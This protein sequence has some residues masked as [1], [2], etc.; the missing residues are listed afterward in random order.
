[1]ADTVLE[2]LEKFGNKTF[3]RL[4]FGEVDAL[5][6]SQ[7]SY[8]KFDGIV[9]GPDD[10]DSFVSLTDIKNHPK[11]DDLFSD[12]RYEKPN[13]K[14]FKLMSESVRFGD[15][16]LDWYVNIIGDEREI[17]FS[18]VTFRFPEG[19]DYVAY[20]GTDENMVG[21]KED[22]NLSIMEEIPG[23]K[24]AVK[25]LKEAAK[26]LNGNFYV[27]GHSKG[28][29]N[30]IY[31]SSAAPASVKKRIMGIYSFDGPA[32][33]EDVRNK[34]DYAGIRD[35]YHKFVPKSSL[36]G[37]IFETDDIY[38]VVKNK[39]AGILQHDPYNWIVDGIDFA[40]EDSLSKSAEVVNTAMA[41]WLKGLDKSARSR[42][43]DCVFE[44]ADACE[45]ND[46]VS[47]ALNPVRSIRQ[48]LDGY[49]RMEDG[50]REFLK[51][52]LN[53][54]IK[55]TGGS[56]RDEVKEGWGEFTESVDKWIDMVQGVIEEKQASKKKTSGKKGVPKK[57]PG[58]KKTKG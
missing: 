12:K 58:K 7:F 34:L 41:N 52:V 49:D 51:E 35:R 4:P 14:L 21:W 16:K 48:M 55:N 15:L 38:T 6:L 43:I 47:I 37:M 30:A 3:K 24:E 27:G 20:R 25:Y 10:M 19:I 22:A 46:L 50:E 45:D 42:F 28:G 2:Y 8:L 17:Q 31:A 40:Y 23:E 5:I 29:L 1:M 36:I 9:P 53:G 11:F 44:V 13:R 57:L 18:A 54:L 26:V 33:R 39:A 56:A 32:I